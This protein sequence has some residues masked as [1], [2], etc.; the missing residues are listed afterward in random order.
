MQKREAAFRMGTFGIFILV[1]VC[2]IIGSRNK[3][4][5]MRRKYGHMWRNILRIFTINLAYAQINTA[6]PTVLTVPLP[7]LYLEF[8]ENWNWVNIDLFSLLSLECIHTSVDFR[9][10][11]ILATLV[12]I[13]TSFCFACVFL[14]KNKVLLAAFGEKNSKNKKSPE[15]R[16]QS[17]MSRVQAIEYLYRS[18]D[19]DENGF[20]DE[21]EFRHV[22]NLLHVKYNHETKHND[23]DIRAL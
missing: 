13:C 12:P 14:C 18:V 2:T 20:M 1:A 17:N 11:V 15:S 4:A 3:L 7:R 8:L 10:R 5:T 19:I 23:R 16:K 22:L 6:L 21:I 9:F